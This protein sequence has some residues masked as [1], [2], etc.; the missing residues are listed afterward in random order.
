MRD[1]LEAH[2]A[3]PGE[4][5]VSIAREPPVM[6]SPEATKLKVLVSELDRLC[7]DARSIREKITEIAQ[8]PATW[9]VPQRVDDSRSGSPQDLN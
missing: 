1:R 2:F 5:G 3:I 8:R 7:A 4:R 9:P 6:D